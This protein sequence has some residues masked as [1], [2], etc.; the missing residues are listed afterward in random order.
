[1]VLKFLYYLVLHFFFLYLQSMGNFLLDGRLNLMWEPD[2]SGEIHLVMVI[3]T[4]MI[5]WQQYQS[6]FLFI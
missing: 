3:C 4:V 2:G 1:M 5:S 6:S